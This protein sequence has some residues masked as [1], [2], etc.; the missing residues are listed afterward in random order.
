MKSLRS[1]GLKGALGGAAIFAGITCA[2]AAVVYSN[3]YTPLPGNTLSYAYEAN[4][5]DELFDRVNL[6]PGGRNLQSITVTMSDWALYSTYATNPLYNGNTA[7]YNQD[8][9]VDFYDG[10]TGSVLLGTKTITTLIPWR[11]EATANCTATDPATPKGYGPNCYHG[12]A[13]NVT[14]DFT[15]MGVVLPNNVYFGIA[16][17]TQD[18]GDDPTHTAGPYNSL[19]V[20]VGP[21][22][23]TVGSDDP[24]YQTN[25]AAQISATAVPEPSTVSLFGIALVG[26][27]IATRRRRRVA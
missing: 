11:P 6:G 7:G 14:F 27:G 2:Q 26:L 18:Y 22:V 19:N 5:I 3:M 23:A 10:A 13:F 24:G 25:I 12:I 16:F 20:G 1:V 8:L 9:T 17:N 21:G 15:G 4:G